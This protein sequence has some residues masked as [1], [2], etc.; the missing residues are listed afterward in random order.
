M[1]ASRALP[2]IAV[3]LVAWWG[4]A[5]TH[6]PPPLAHQVAALE[7]AASRAMLTATPAARGAPVDEGIVDT[8]SGGRVPID[9]VRDNRGLPWFA[10][11]GTAVWTRSREGLVL[12]AL[13]GRAIERVAGAT[14]IRETADG[15][16][17]AYRLGDDW[18][19]VSP[20]GARHV[21]GP[22][23]YPSLSPDGRYFVFE[24]S[25]ARVREVHAVD[26]STGDE[27]EVAR[28]LGRCHCTSP[29]GYGYPEWATSGV[30]FTFRDH[31]DFLAQP[32]EPDSGAAFI[33]DLATRRLTRT[34]LASGQ[35]SRLPR[36]GASSALWN[37]DG[38]HRLDYTRM[39]ALPRTGATPTP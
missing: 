34:S 7:A 31:G 35:A 19:V 2:Y 25:I 30:A 29:D 22:L 9:A 1:H 6:P 24:R 12:I 38:V 16:V 17:R 14:D 26:L 10:R 11:D 3:A 37:V 28:G 20:G 23:T 5:N 18:S 21:M 36:C 33:Y 4:V 27:I 13:D 15:G 39:C 8:H 32:E